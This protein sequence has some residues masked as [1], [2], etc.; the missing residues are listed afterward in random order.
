MQCDRRQ[1]ERL[2]RL[3]SRFDGRGVVHVVPRGHQ[4]LPAS[5]PGSDLDVFVAPD[6]F[7]AA[8]VACEAVG[9]EPGGS[10]VA[11]AGRLLSHAL[12]RPR[13]AVQFALESPEEVLPYVRRQLSPGE[14]T[15]RGLLDRHYRDGELD[16][17]L[18]NHLAYVSPMNGQRIRVDPEVEAAMLDRRVDGEVGAVPAPPDELLHLVC[19]GVFDYGG[20]FPTYY[21]RRVDGLVDDVT[22]DPTA[23][24]QFRGVL[25]PVFFAAA[26][27]VYD[28]VVAGDYDAV[29]PA[30]Y[31]FADY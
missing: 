10:A 9:L 30:L 28:H 19:R 22:A 12:K 29:R 23:D 5:F 27:L 17:H 8:T 25:E 31:R 14:P 15:R 2:R 7:E 18:F 16:V 3:F 13:T 6:S 20:S 11:T 26:D 1:Q 21:R 24:E 4:R